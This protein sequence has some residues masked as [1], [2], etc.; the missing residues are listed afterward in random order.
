M[1]RIDQS[2]ISCFG[3]VVPLS[4]RSFTARILGRGNDFEILALQLFVNF[5]PARQI[6]AAASP[7][8]PGDHQHFLAAEIRKMNDATL[9]IR[10]REV[11]R[12]PGVIKASPKHRD[13]AEAPDA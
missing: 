12:D 11:G 7:G 13:L 9:T 8:S 6:E 3:L 2:R 10:G 5:L 1:L 4:S